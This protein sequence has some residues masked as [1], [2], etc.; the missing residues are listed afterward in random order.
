MLNQPEEPNDSGGDH[1]VRIYQEME[2]AIADV[3]K[4]HDLTVG[5]MM[6]IQAWIVASII[7]GTA[8]PLKALG[9]FSHLLSVALSVHRRPPPDSP[10]DTPKIITP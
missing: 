5:D 7:S 1:W 10:T 2:T 8:K 3:A 6:H 9:K 4:R